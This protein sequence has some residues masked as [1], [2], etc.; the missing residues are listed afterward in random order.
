MKMFYQQIVCEQSQPD[1]RGEE[2]RA[3]REF[4]RVLRKC[5]NASVA[6][7]RVYGFQGFHHDKPTSIALPAD[8]FTLATSPK[9]LTACYLTYYTD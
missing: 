4:V 5:I 2:K 7:R 6:G 3:R 1:E 9:Y 8:R